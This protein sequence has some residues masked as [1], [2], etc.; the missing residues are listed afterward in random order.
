MPVTDTGAGYDTRA[1]SVI[2]EDMYDCAFSLQRAVELYRDTAP[3]DAR[4]RLRLLLVMGGEAMR[5]L[6]L[7]EELSGAMGVEFRFG[8]L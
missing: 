1:V 2:A 5:L 6:S 3:D 4:T 7:A 8:G